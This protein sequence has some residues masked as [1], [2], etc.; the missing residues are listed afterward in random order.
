MGAL[1]LT[2]PASVKAWASIDQDQ[3]KEDLLIESLISS[4]S[5][6]V[7]GWL[8]RRSLINNKFTDV[9]S[10]VPGSRILLR[11]YPVTSVASILNGITVV[12]QNKLSPPAGSGWI[13]EPWDGF[14]PGKSQ[15][16]SVNGYLFYG[17]ITV[18]YQ[19][20][21]MVVSE[22]QTI[23]GSP[24]Q[25]APAKPYGPWWGDAGAVY[26]SSRTALQAMPP[27][28]SLTAGQYIP[29]QPFASTPVSYYQYAAADTGQVVLLSY[30]YIPSGVEGA[31]A[32]LIGEHIMYRGRIGEKS[33]SMGGNESTSYELTDLPKW[34]QFALQSYRRVATN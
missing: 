19:A 7:L 23:P 34:V 33:R 13:L 1:D 31:V 18:T 24:F 6:V 30:S 12:P 3:T 29:P 15:M 8:G 11:N 25:V 20:G 21:Y 28:T 26:A 27:G 32:R 4:T 22:P 9:Y 5:Q 10:N 17:D 2:T 16:L 14:P